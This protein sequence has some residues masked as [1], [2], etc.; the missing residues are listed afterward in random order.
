MRAGTGKVAR[1]RNVV[2]QPVEVE[3]MVLK[4][5]PRIA[6]SYSCDWARDWGRAVGERGEVR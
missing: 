2:V 4:A 5:D 1:L 3:A 6:S